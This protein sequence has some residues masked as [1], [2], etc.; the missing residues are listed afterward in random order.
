MLEKYTPIKLSHNSLDGI[1]NYHLVDG[2]ISTSGQPTEEQFLL[3]K[4]AGYKTIINLAPHNTENSLPDEAGVLRDLGLEYVHIPVDFK[5]PTTADFDKFVESIGA[6][7]LDKT[8]IHCAA[9]MRVSA[10]VFRYRCDVLNQDVEE[11]RKDLAKI[12]KP[13]G[14]WK[15]FVLSRQ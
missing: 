9:N 6:S 10:F 11:A 3:I 2:R 4:D 15:K 13:I 8:W 1:F 5:A 14:A 7:K 12:W